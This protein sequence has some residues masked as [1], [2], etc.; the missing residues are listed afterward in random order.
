MDLKSLK[1]IALLLPLMLGKHVIASDTSVHPN[2]VV[3]ITDDQGYGDLG[4]HGNEIIKTPNLDS[5]YKQAIRFTNFHVSPTCAPTRSSI[6]TGRYANRV[7]VWHTIGGRSLLWDDEVTMA[8]VFAKNG[9]T[10]GLFGKWHLGD[11]YPFRPEDRGFHEVVVHGGGGITQG[12]DYWGNDYFDDFYRHNGKFER[13][14]GYCTDVFFDEALKF[15]E[16]NKSQPFFCYISTNAPHGPLNVPATYHEMYKDEE[17]LTKQQRRF[18]GMITNIDDNFKRLRDRLKELELDENTILIYMTDNG[19]AYGYRTS[20]GISYGNNGGMRGAK[21]SEY[22][23]G[24]R[25]PFFISYPAE[26]LTVNRDIDQLAAHIDMLP[27]F[28]DLC[29]L[30]KIPTHK[31]FDGKSLAPKILDKKDEPKDRVLVVDSQRRQNLVKWRKSA[32]MKG[33]WRLIN[34]KELYDLNTDPMQK[35]DVALGNP[36]IVKELRLGYEKW[37]ESIIS[38]GANERYAYIQVGANAEN[39]VRISA[40]DMHTESTHAH[41]QHGPLLG[42][43]PLGIFKVEV[44]HEGDYTISL[45]RFPRESML[46]FNDNV[47]AVSP[48]FE[49]EKGMPASVSIDIKKAFLSMADRDVNVTVLGNT[50]EAQFKLHLQPGKFDLDAFFLDDNG[51]KYPPYYIYIEKN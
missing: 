49:I 12:P 50:K 34:G 32:V 3:V 8:D 25:V 26:N 14:N 30:D 19:S 4:C 45:C 44:L 18:Y 5:F 41:S 27:T 47:D 16:Q 1:P 36:N 46:N 10:N 35:S 39:P 15:I 28:I 9:Y 23:G 13:Y 21:N 42:L 20:K 43:N 40:H 24:H 22:E 17:R 37:W 6:M 33:K 51:V 38:E 11:N 2:V 48:S 31:A 7:G 29:K